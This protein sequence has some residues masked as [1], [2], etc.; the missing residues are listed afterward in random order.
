MYA[1]LLTAA[2][3]LVG[4]ST[5]PYWHDDMPDYRVKNI[6]VRESETLIT[7][8]VAA[9]DWKGDGCIKRFQD[10]AIIFI[11]KGLNK[12]DY[13]C[14]MRHEFEHALGKGHGQGV[15]YKKMCD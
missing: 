15:V 11:R 5:T 14:V 1:A 13:E 3:L 7:D 4:C 12:A 2:V 10:K 9:P 6:E 8:C